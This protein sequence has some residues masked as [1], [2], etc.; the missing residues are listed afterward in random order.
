LDR[1]LGD[2]RGEAVQTMTDVGLVSTPDRRALEG[3]RREDRERRIGLGTV[4]GEAGQDLER[5]A[6]RIGPIGLRP[7]NVGQR[8]RLV[9]TPSARVERARPVRALD[10]DRVRERLTQ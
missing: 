10:P 5:V 8:E 2:V 7:Q 1:V 4:P 6:R 3:V 9:G